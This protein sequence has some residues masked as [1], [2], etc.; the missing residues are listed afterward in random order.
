MHLYISKKLK[1]I[2]P[3]QEV[4][5][6]VNKIWRQADPPRNRIVKHP[7]Q[8]SFLPIPWK[9]WEIQCNP[10]LCVP[11]VQPDF[12]AALITKDVSGKTE[13]AVCVIWKGGHIHYG[14]YRHL[15]YLGMMSRLPRPPFSWEPEASLPPNIARYL[16]VFDDLE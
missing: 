1:G 14:Q 6:Q 16:P 3:R 15:L 5:E 2:V 9:P 11:P 7:V 4:W 8:S 13:V 10:E 12:A